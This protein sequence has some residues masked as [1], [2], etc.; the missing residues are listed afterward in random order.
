MEL[1]GRTFFADADVRE[2]DLSG[3]CRG[4]MRREADGGDPEHEVGIEIRATW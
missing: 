2:R 3:A 1:K 4:R